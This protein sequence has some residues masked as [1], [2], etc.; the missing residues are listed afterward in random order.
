MGSSDKSNRDNQQDIDLTR[1][2]SGAD[3]QDTESMTDEEMRDSDQ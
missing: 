2:E 3:M 1:D